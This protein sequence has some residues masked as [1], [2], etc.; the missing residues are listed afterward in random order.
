MVVFTHRDLKW[1]SWHGKFYA[2]DATAPESHA[3]TNRVVQDHVLQLKEVIIGADNAA[4]LD[5]TVER[6]LRF[7]TL[8]G[9]TVTAVAGVAGVDNEFKFTAGMHENTEAA[10]QQC[11]ELI[12]LTEN[13]LPA[14]SRLLLTSVYT[15]NIQSRIRF[16]MRR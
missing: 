6:G 16:V 8:G 14:M 4:G 11:K 15:N 7:A 12:Q 2:G 9:L 10:A 13:A 3:M 5:T 1:E